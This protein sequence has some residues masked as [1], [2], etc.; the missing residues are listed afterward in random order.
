MVTSQEIED[1]ELAKVHAELLA[2]R[3]ELLKNESRVAPHDISDASKSARN[4]CH[5]LALRQRDIRPLQR[6]LARLGLSSLGRSEAH[7]LATIDAVIGITGRLLGASGPLARGGAA[8]TFDEGPYLLLQG[9]AA[10]FGPRANDRAT[11]IMVTLS[12]SAARDPQ[13][14]DQLVAA[15]MDAVRINCAH[16]DAGVWQRM[17]DHVRTA[18]RTRG[19]P[20]IVHFDLAGPKIR[21]CGMADTVKLSCGDELVLAATSVDQGADRPVVRCT[22]PEVL[23]GVRPG[24]HVW[25]DDGKL[26]GVVDRS[27][28]GGVVVRISHAH[29]ERHGLSNDRGVNLPDTPIDVPGFTAKDREDLEF[30]VPHADTIA[31]SFAQ[32]P[33]DVQALQGALVRHGRSKCG[34]I[35][36]IETRR[37][38]EAL[39]EM[40]LSHRGPSPLGVMIARGDLAVEV[41][42][43]RLAEVQEE[44]LWICEAAHTPVIWATQVLETL[45][46]DGL[47]TRAEVSDAAMSSRAEC[48]MLN[49]GKHLVETVR[50]LDDILR[51][52]ADHQQKKS[53]M[54][55][56]LRVSRPSAKPGDGPRTLP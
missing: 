34:I 39:P 52:M 2:L 3:A 46:K 37:G 10:L 9:E 4:L 55:R 26:G 38:F 21:T 43:E 18:S 35:L 7:V 40:L 30:V 29:D 27:I 15:G 31:L 44:I 19:R 45:A 49:K 28:E 48:V 12:T 5:Y 56:A 6:T 17:V 24:H 47:P 54:L 41:G 32:R 51:R 1:Q 13:Q 20:C 11:R 16:D 36:K 23:A 50:I 33:E 42:Y 22:I 8:P 14:I 25:F 53:A